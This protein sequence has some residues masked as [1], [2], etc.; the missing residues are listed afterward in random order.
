MFLSNSNDSDLFPGPNI[1]AIFSYSMQ[2][3]TETIV[4]YRHDL[5]LDNFGGWHLRISPTGH[6]PD[7]KKKI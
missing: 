6:L 5:P 2:T 3:P 7:R 1:G 4:T